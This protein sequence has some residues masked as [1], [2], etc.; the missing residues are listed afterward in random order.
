MRVLKLF[1]ILIFI[2]ALSSMVYRFSDKERTLTIQCTVRGAVTR[3]MGENVADFGW[4]LEPYN[5]DLFC[6][7]KTSIDR[8][9]MISSK[10]EDVYV[11]YA[12]SFS[13][14]DVQNVPRMSKKVLPLYLRKRIDDMG[15]MKERED[16]FIRYRVVE[17]TEEI[18]KVA[19]FTAPRREKERAFQ[20][21]QSRFQ[22]LKLFTLKM[23][24]IMCV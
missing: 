8:I 7:K 12:S 22:I 2:A 4:L 10:R 11:N 24:A 16:F 5:M 18:L 17:E 15:I 13:Y 21:L 19:Y 3:T 6:F 14:F 9:N 23:C 20:A 1:S